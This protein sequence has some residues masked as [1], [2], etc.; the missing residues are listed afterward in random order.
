M[1]T[2]SADGNR[3][4]RD[5]VQHEIEC[6]R[7]ST[8]LNDYIRLHCNTGLTPDEE[9]LLALDGE[10]SLSVDGRLLA[11]QRWAWSGQSDLAEI[12]GLVG[13]PDRPCRPLEEGR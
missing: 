1:P 11:L 4:S 12:M 6:R 8:A 5:D 7:G 10:L 9:I 3:L 13:Q 2:V